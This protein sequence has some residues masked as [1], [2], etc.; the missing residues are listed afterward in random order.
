MTLEDLNRNKYPTDQI[1]ESNL[2][3]TYQRAKVVE[4]HWMAL[5]NSPFVVTSGLRSAGQ[6]AN[7]VKAG[8]ST[9][10]RSKHLVGLAV[11]IL[12]KDDL[13]KKFLRENPLHLIHAELWCEHWEYTLGWCHLQA[14]PPASGNRWFIP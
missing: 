14:S 2:L 5:G 12:D 4:A 9:A 1:I 13:L 8:K 10:I 6:Q 3:V 7:L 11:D